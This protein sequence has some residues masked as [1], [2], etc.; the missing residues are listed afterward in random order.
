MQEL[1][2]PSYPKYGIKE[3]KIKSFEWGVKLEDLSFHILF[4]QAAEVSFSV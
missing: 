4:V 3:G 1:E 2:I